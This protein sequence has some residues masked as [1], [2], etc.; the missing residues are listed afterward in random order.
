MIQNQQMAV[1]AESCVY[2]IPKFD[3]VSSQKVK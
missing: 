3:H 2:I 1:A